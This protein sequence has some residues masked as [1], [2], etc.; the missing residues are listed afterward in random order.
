MGIRLFGF[1]IWAQRQR[2]PGGHDPI[3]PLHAFLDVRIAQM[4]TEVAHRDTSRVDTAQRVFLREQNFDLRP[5]LKW[6]VYGDDF[7]IVSATSLR[8]FGR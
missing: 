3:Q 5:P 7:A 6:S 8:C 2:Y 1:D 4:R